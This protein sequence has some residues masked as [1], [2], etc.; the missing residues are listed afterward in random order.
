[1]G[2]WWF[3]VDARV[4]RHDEAVVDGHPGHL[5]EHVAAQ[6]RRLVRRRVAAQGRGVDPARLRGVQGQG[7]HVRVAVVGRDGAVLLEVAAAAL[8]GAQVA[9]EVAGVLAG[10]LGECSHELR[11][12]GAARL[13]V[14]VGA[15]GGHHA[16]GERR[17]PAPRF[18]AA[19]P[20]LG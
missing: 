11:E 6:S 17:V 9:G 4:E 18:A 12:V 20:C 14:A 8:Q 5:D 16:P 7:D 10:G 2:V 13:E 3:A 1:M 15:E 19:A